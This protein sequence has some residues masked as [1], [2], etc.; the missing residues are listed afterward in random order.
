M[1]ILI[2]ILSTRSTICST[3]IQHTTISISIVRYNSSIICVASSGVYVYIYTSTI[4]RIIH[5]TIEFL[6][7]HRKNK[8]N[9]HYEIV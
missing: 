7:I 2:Y 6:R 4:N 3:S 8:N 9:G 1:Y 5:A